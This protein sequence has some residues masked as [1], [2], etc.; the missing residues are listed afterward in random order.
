MQCVWGIQL[1]TDGDC[2][3]LV[4]GP[5][6]KEAWHVAGTGYLGHTELLADRTGTNDFCM[7]LSSE[8]VSS[9]L[10]S[11]HLPLADAI[12]CLSIESISRAI[13]LGGLAM[14]TKHGRPPTIVVLGLNPHAGENGLLSR[15]EEESLIQPAIDAVDEWQKSQGLGWHLIGPCP[16]RYGVHAREQK[17]R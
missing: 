11:I 9:V 7:M 13:R 14:Q 15:G 1:A 17:N 2:D 3:A 5:I 10:C 16:A 6:Q 8:L 4:T 12:Q